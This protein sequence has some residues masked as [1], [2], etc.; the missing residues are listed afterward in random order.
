MCTEEL[1]YRPCVTFLNKLV[2]MVR[3][4]VY[5]VNKI[6]VLLYSCRNEY[7]VKVG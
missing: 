3:N 7:I 6:L 2:F 1:L 5:L 4:W